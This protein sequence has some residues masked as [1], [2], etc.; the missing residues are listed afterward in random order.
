[1]KGGDV[2]LALDAM[3]QL[4][5]GGNRLPTLTALRASR[6]KTALAKA[7]APLEERRMQLC[8]DHGTLEPGAKTFSFPSKEGQEAFVAG[9]NELATADVEVELEALT[10][11]DLEGGYFR[12]P[13]TGKREDGLDLAP[14]VF[15]V[16]ERLEILSALPLKPAQDGGEGG[17]FA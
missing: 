11:A 5:G 2:K 15:G 7:W 8:K 16:L 13:N 1:M 12:D 6:I 17:P 10:P 4:C 9:W 14:E 3:D